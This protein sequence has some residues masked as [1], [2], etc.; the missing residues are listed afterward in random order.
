MGHLMPK[1]PDAQICESPPGG[2]LNDPVFGLS[3][4]I[5]TTLDKQVEGKGQARD[6][7]REDAVV[8][9]AAGCVIT[10]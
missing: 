9:V 4:A 6:A 3:E 5:S 10:G 7:V 2:C 8:N 1:F